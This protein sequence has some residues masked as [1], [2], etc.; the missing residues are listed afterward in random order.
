[1]TAP[2]KLSES[3]VGRP[4]GPVCG[5]IATTGMTLRASTTV[6]VTMIA[7]S[8]SVPPRRDRYRRSQPTSARRPPA[9]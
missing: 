6:G 2:A 3:T 8:M 1:M 9:E 5:S 4:D 7:P